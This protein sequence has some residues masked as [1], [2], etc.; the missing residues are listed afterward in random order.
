MYEKELAAMIKAALNAEEGILAVY[1]KP[2]EVVLK[3]DNSPVTEADR[4][5]D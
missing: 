2:F 4:F 5:A 1:S 3:E